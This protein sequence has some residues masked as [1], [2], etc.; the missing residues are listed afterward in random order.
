MKH[1][2]SKSFVF[3][4]V[5]AAV[6]LIQAASAHRQN[7]ILPFP[8]KGVAVT[9][10]TGSPD[11][12]P[13]D[14]GN[15]CTSGETCRSGICVSP[16]TFAEATGSPVGVGA[17][18]W[19]VAVADFNLD[20]RPDLAVANLDSNNVT[21]LLGNGSGG[22]AE[23]PG[24]PVAVGLSPL[25]VEIG[26]FNLDGN[27]DL[28]VANYGSNTVTILL[29]D[30]SGGFT[31]APES[32]VDVGSGPGSV[33]ISDFDLDGKP[34]L[35]L[36][37][38]YSGNVTILLGDGSGEFREA[39]GSP[40][41]VGVSPSFVVAGDFS[42]DNKPD[43]AIASTVGTVSIQLGNGSG[44]F[45]EAPGSPVGVEENPTFIAIGDFNLDNTPDLVVTDYLSA[46]ITILL[47]DG[48]GGFAEAAGSPVAVGMNPVAA[49]IG[50]FNLDNR[51]DLAVANDD[52]HGNVTILLGNGSGGFAAAAS[53]PVP[54]GSRAHSVA[55]G[56]FDVDGKPDIA[57]ANFGSATVTIMLGN[58]GLAPDGTSCSDGNGCTVSD[59]CS[60]GLCT[61]GPPVICDDGNSCTIDSC[62]PKSGCQHAPDPS[63]NQP[64]DCQS[65]RP[66]QD[67]LWPPHHEMV[68]IDILGVGD[69]DGDPVSVVVTGIAQDEAVGIGRGAA[70]PDGTGIGTNRATLRSERDGNGD[71]RVYIVSF[72]AHDGRGGE[73]TGV[74]TV[75]V[76][77]DEGDNA[78]GDQGPIASSEG[79][80]GSSPP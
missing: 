5:V 10:C 54:V 77:H 52:D 19:R 45:A 29:G 7:G 72:I 47:G 56:D 15:A 43:L 53:S 64:P 49:S 58:P 41:H 57:V 35:A 18:P 31:T 62:D 46:A 50:D 25:T 12:T 48:S 69:P 80:C 78:C 33:A 16:V 40:V 79:P 42:R 14:D 21:I 76:P 63:C 2:R 13:C 65:A 55:V 22:F 51:P 34:D 39:S 59:T 30:G 27:P 9:D 73:C 60:N 36:S 6:G 71:G 75:C 28:A 61:G 74:V 20:H 11:G 23:A 68:P 26:D 37:A 3:T 4:I 1:L 67:K 70:C 24:S 38:Y 17:G 66:S 44:G 8:P 32:P